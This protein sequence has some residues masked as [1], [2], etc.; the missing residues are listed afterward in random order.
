PVDSYVRPISFPTSDRSLD[1]LV[2]IDAGIE[3]EPRLRAAGLSREQ[4][5]AIFDLAQSELNQEASLH[6]PR[7]E[8]VAPVGDAAAYW[9]LIKERLMSMGHSQ[10][11]IARLYSE[12][13]EG[14]AQVLLNILAPQVEPDA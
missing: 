3:L 8:D 6:L 4:V 12:A 5:A 1:S 9:I 13:G 7:G 2:A 10:A 14:Q 11:D